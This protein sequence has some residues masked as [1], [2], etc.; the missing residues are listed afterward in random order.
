MAEHGNS[1]RNTKQH[2]LYEIRD[3]VDDDVFKYGI[4]HGPV[5]SDG[6][7][8]RMREQVNFLNLGVKWLRF[9]ARILISNISGRKEAKRI[10]RH[11]IRSYKEKNGQNPRGNLTD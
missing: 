11:Y 1:N 7:S 4:S 10:E 6:Y 3:S 9:F 5:G 2:H 8:D